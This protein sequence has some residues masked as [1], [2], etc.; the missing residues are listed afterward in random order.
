[1]TW[2]LA[3]RILQGVGAAMLMPTS[4]AILGTSFTG[5][6]RGRAI[7]TWAATGAGAGAIGPLIGGWLIDLAGWRAMFLINVPIA[8]AAMYLGARYIVD[9]PSPNPAPL[10]WP[11]A[12]LVTAGLAALTWGLTLVSSQQGAPATAWASSRPLGVLTTA[13]RI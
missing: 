12:A 11:G 4:L 6:A 2:L 10:D 13:L 5:E 1:M 8:L 3:G 9:R 7:G